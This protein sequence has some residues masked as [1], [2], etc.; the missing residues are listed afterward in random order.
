MP[1]S[2]L[3]PLILFND[4]DGDWSRFEAAVY[5]QCKRD[6]IDSTPLFNIKNFGFDKRISNGKEWRYWHLI[7]EGPVEPDREPSIE[8]CEKITWIRPIIEEPHNPRVCA[9][10]NSRPRKYGKGGVDKR[11]V[12]STTDFSYIVIFDDKGSWANLLTAYPI[13]NNKQKE[14]L[15]KEYEGW[16]KAGGAF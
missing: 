4:Y 6:L 13:N 8:R 14:K 16:K 2:W 15:Q 1:C 12:L 7:S 3:P 5:A 9:W 10:Q 11:I